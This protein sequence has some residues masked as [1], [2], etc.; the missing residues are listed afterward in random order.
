LPSL[1]P[2]NHHH[3]NN[4]N[5]TSTVSSSSSRSYVLWKR[6]LAISVRI[7]D[8]ETTGTVCQEEEFLTNDDDDDDTCILTD[9]TNKNTSAAVVSFPDDSQIVYSYSSTKAYLM[10][11][12]NHYL[13]EHHL[14][15]QYVLASPTDPQCFGEP[16]LQFL[17]WNCWVGPDNIFLNWLLALQAPN[18]NNN[19]DATSTSTSTTG[20]VY[21]PK[22]HRLQE[23]HSPQQPQGK[24]SNNNNT[25][26]TTTTHRLVSL[27]F[28]LG[29][30]LHITFLYFFCTTLV[31]FTL[32]ETQERM[33]EFT[34]ELSRRVHLSLPLQ[35]LI[36]THVVQNLVFVPIM[37]GMMFFLI[38]FYSGD[39]FLAFMVLSIVWCVEVFSVIR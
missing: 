38:E 28:K 31:S 34:Q 30:L 29:V 37:V 9:N 17:V 22:T 10:L 39:K 27:L 35:G 32:R 2:N 4:N 20:Y 5:N 3:N 13:L 21:H 19:I 18:N 14:S 16:F 25:R 24:S 8:N 1:P 12:S 26:P 6:P 7:N 15:I 33:L 23:L 11:P 36:T